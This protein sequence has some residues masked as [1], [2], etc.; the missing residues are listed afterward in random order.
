MSSD[1]FKRYNMKLEAHDKFLSRR[2]EVIQE[3]YYPPKKK[4]VIIP[5][6][7]GRR[8]RA[9]LLRK[10]FIDA[11]S[12]QTLSF[13]ESLKGKGAIDSFEFKLGIQDTD[14]KT[15]KEVYEE[16]DRVLINAP[17]SMKKLISE[18]SEKGNDSFI[19]QFTNLSINPQEFFWG[20]VSEY[21]KP[22]I[23]NRFFKDKQY[24]T[25]PAMKSVLQPETMTDKRKGRRQQVKESPPAPIGT[26]E[27][28]VDFDVSELTPELKREIE[29][30][31]QVRRE[32]Y[33][34]HYLTNE[35]GFYAD[36][37]N[38]QF[39]MIYAG[40][41]QFENRPNDYAQFE[42]PTLDKIEKIV[43]K[44]ALLEPVIY[45]GKSYAGGKRKK[46][47][48]LAIVKEGTGKIHIN[49]KTFVDYFSTTSIRSL[50][51]DPLLVSGYS[52]GLDVDFFIWGGGVH[53]QAEAA[54]LA[55]S[56]ALVKYNPGVKV[57]MREN[58]LLNQDPRQTER[59]HVGK[60]KAR[61]KFPYS[62]R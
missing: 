7:A 1:E 46:A 12:P 61:A 56:K 53:A 34:K 55:L 11:E 35:L 9:E 49:R 2:D 52:V 16:L 10:S 23:P 32:P 48:A 15:F 42:K 51:I 44:Q 58:G 18:N 50:V 13:F 31:R 62:R 14:P 57:A 41:T 21:L 25:I 60:Y 43:M 27:Q 20:N 28:E 45:N 29:I 26:P 24:E 33:F 54:S 8:R 30:F 40:L 47:K 38:D 36:R 19:P 6:Q 3:I 5:A 37:M 59:K 22:V 4:K 17:L 39:S